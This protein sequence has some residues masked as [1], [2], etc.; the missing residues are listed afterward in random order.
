MIRSNRQD[1]ILDMLA[2][3][4]SLSVTD[5]ADRLDVSS[6]TIRR[7]LRQL[8]EA[9]EVV[10]THGRAALSPRR[11]EAPFDRRMREN[12][13]AKREIAALVAAMVVDGDSVMMD[14]GTTTSFVARALLA[15]RGLTIVTNSSD[16][17]RTLAIVNDNTVFMAGGQLRA[18]NGAAFGTAAVEFVRRFK[19][20]HA[21]V[22]IGAIDARSGA[23]NFDLD[24]AEFGR[25]V[26]NCG[27]HRMIVTD[28]AKFGRTA[29]VKVCGLGDFDALVT[30][31]PP[32]PD[33]AEALDQ[34]GTRVVLPPAR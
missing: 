27:E 23:M 33:L 19:V 26:L 24:E 21:I 28:A 3:A 11:G 30:D 16:V 8:V 17:A 29:L 22:T 34:H 25:E 6:E 20:R 14:T 15:R 10:K 32:P 18:D 5:L 12:A 2:A 4:G 9:G 7:N 13:D 1:A 31:L